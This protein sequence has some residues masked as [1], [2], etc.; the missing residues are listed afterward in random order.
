MIYELLLIPDRGVHY[1][2]LLVRLLSFAQNGSF[3]RWA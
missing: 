3:R 2:Y 1:A